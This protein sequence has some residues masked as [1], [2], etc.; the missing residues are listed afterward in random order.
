MAGREG[1]RAGGQSTGRHH[2]DTD[3]KA[4]KPPPAYSPVTPQQPWSG[5]FPC[6]YRPHSGCVRH[7]PGSRA[8]H[9]NRLL[10]RNDPTPPVS[11][12]KKNFVRKILSWFST[13]D[14]SDVLQDSLSEVEHKATELSKVDSAS[15]RDAEGQFPTD[16]QFEAQSFA[17]IT[18]LHPTMPYYLSYY[19][20]DFI[21]RKR[22]ASREQD[23][24]VPELS[25]YGTSNFYRGGPSYTWSSDIYFD[26]H[27]FWQK[28]EIVYSLYAPCEFL[29][30]T[31]CP[32]LSFEL[33]RPKVVSNKGRV[34]WRCR[35]RL[36]PPAPLYFHGY[37]KRWRSETGHHAKLDGCPVCLNDA[38][39]NMEAI[40]NAL[41]VR[42]T[43]YRDLGHGTERFTQN[44]NSLLTGKVPYENLPNLPTRFDTYS[45]VSKI[46]ARV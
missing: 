43:L 29:K 15:E 24:H 46:T 6:V 18:P 40:G 32:H 36:R 9:Y 30:F 5:H 17:N 41:R 22:L 45:R 28:Q 12:E 20:L 3:T 14:S 4:R 31:M 44:W 35:L 42:Y 2:S 39:S 38:E 13:K 19:H 27:K 11:E 26:K 1:K 8:V 33:K 10:P 23:P 7:N 21:R 25:C 37:S 34:L 16:L